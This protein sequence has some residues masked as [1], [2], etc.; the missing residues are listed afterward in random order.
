MLAF[1]ERWE[2]DTGLYY[3]GNSPVEDKDSDHGRERKDNCWDSV[4][5][6]MRRDGIL[7]TGGGAGLV[8]SMETSSMTAVGKVTHE[9]AGGI[10][11]GMWLEE[12]MKAL[13]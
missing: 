7:C 5:E 4:L 3:T 2:N 11:V 1:R 10:K 6:E 12:S 8:R 13:F 9:G